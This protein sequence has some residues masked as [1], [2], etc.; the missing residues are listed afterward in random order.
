MLGTELQVMSGHAVAMEAVQITACMTDPAF[1]S[2]ESLAKGVS[3][4]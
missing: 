2:C 4:M 1:V 3:S